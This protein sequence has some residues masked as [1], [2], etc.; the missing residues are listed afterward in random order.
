MVVQNDGTSQVYKGSVLAPYSNT[1]ITVVPLANRKTAAC[2]R[3]TF[4]PYWDNSPAVR[5]AILGKDFLEG[6][7]N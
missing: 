2:L 1:C 7:N 5:P 3:F 6:L 4:P